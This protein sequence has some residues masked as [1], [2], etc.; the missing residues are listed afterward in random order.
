[1]YRQGGQN[2]GGNTCNR[3]A[4]R[5]QPAT[6]TGQ[7]TA[8]RAYTSGAG[9]FGSSG[10]CCELSSGWVRYTLVGSAAGGKQAAQL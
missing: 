6:E 5:G 3:I 8:S 10:R 4:H 9:N 1:M 7:R 2:Q